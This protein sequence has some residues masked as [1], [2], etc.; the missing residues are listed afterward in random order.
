MAQIFVFAA[1]CHPSATTSYLLYLKAFQEVGGRVADKT[2]K[3]H[4]V[5]QVDRRICEPVHSIDIKHIGIGDSVEHGN[6]RDDVHLGVD[7]DARLRA[8]A[9]GT[10][11]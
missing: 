6:L 10:P 8:S 9:Q 2:R 7:L 3:I 11:C 1:T 5:T 4:C